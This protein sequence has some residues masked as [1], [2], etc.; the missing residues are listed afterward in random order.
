M[1]ELKPLSKE[2]IPAALEK[3]ERY[4]LLNQPRLSESICLDILD[5]DPDNQ[6]TIVLLILSITD[7]FR[8][9]MYR[10]AKQARELIPRLNGEYE[11]LYYS[12]IICERQAKAIF[13]QGQ[14]GSKYDAYEWF[15]EAMGYYEKAEKM[16]PTGNDDAI[17]RWNTCVRIIMDQNLEERP[18]DEFHPF[19]E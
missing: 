5:A 18:A 9:G 10:K 2:G 7:Q 14:P 17:L 4:R 13:N 11:K 1:F 16:H 8:R 12:G 15:C 19:L 6:D 3:A